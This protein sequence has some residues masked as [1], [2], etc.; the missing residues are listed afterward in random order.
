MGTVGF[1]DAILPLIPVGAKMAAGF[2]KF[3]GFGKAPG[4]KFGGAWAPKRDW[5]SWHAPLA[6]W[7]GWGA[8]IGLRADSFPGIDIDITDP[9]L[10]SDITQLAVRLL[11]P[12]PVRIGAWPKRL[13]VY[14]LDGATFGKRSVDLGA[15][16]KVEVLAAGQQYVIWGTHPKT[17][18]PYRYEGR[19]IGAWG[20]A[21]LTAVSAEK[22][23]AFLAAVADWA[24][25]MGLDVAGAIGVS[26]AGPVAVRDQSELTAP[27]VAAV[28]RL[29]EGSENDLDYDAWVKMAAAI[30]AACAGLDPADDGYEIFAE[31]SAGRVDGVIPDEDACRAKWDS[32][33]PPYRIGWGFLVNRSWM[34]GAGDALAEFS[35]VDAGETAESLGLELGEGPAGGLSALERDFVWV[36]AIKRMVRVA[37]GVMFDREQFN[38][39]NWSIGDP[40]D[41]KK[42]AWAKAARSSTLRRL[43][44]VTYRPGQG[45][46]VQEDYGHCLNSWRQPAF[47]PIACGESDVRVWLDH[48]DYLVPNEQERRTVLQFFAF[49]LQR[50]GEKI[51]FALVLKGEHGTG[52]DML[53]EPLR[54]ALGRDNSADIAADALMDGSNVWVLNRRLIVGQEVLIGHKR[55]AMQRLKPLL[56]APPHE[57]EVNQ[58]FIPKFK[59]PNI[60]AVILMTNLDDALAVEDGDRRLFVVDSPNKPREEAYYTGLR[61]WYGT[62]GFERVAGYLAGVDLTGFNAKGRAPETAAKDEMRAMT[63]EPM[64]AFVM[65]AI[66]EEAAPFETDLVLL[67]QV[68]DFL[69]QKWGRPIAAQRV[70]K[71]LGKAGGQPMWEGR[72]QAVGDARYRIWA[73]RRVAIYAHERGDVDGLQNDK[74]RDL[75]LTQRDKLRAGVFNST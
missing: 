10:A 59:V 7:D 75:F 68:R 57:I 30:K 43:D 16:G 17:K 69:A 70:A 66:E 42:C 5:R 40:A 37:D 15:A 2:E 24:D 54:R 74:L 64:T 67:S 50:L 23:D 22:V 58:K 11:G 6:Q 44:G 14:R 28:R 20:S 3:A 34:A 39:A 47:S 36:S 71:L 52:K 73:V 65:D 29:L 32:L 61:D 8:N 26:G 46:F 4:I 53:I 62:G 33:G 60:C 72:I 12:A 35:V 27:S 13:L 38:I 51:N 25:I 1:A 19:A 55:D 41:S 9:A 21:G 48:L 31:F 18:G 49:V 63:R 45:L 56:A